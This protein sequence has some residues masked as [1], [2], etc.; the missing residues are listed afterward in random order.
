MN[1]LRFAFKALFPLLVLMLP[2]CQN[3]QN[4][5]SQS[6]I[7]KAYHDY[8]VPVHRP[9]NPENVRV[10]ISL[11]SQTAYVMEGE[12]ALLVMPVTVG[13]PGFSTPTGSFRIGEKSAK[14]RAVSHGFFRYGDQYVEGWTRDHGG[15]QMVGTPMP[16]WC[17]MAERPEIGMHTEW[18]YPEPH[19]HGCIR[20]HVNVAPRFFAIVHSGTPV[21]IARTQPYDKT[22]GASLKRPPSPA[23]LGEYSIQER[24]TDAF[25][26]RHKPVVFE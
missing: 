14:R 12:R 26:T 23:I 15:R 24:M 8:N 22:L 10:Y 13:R 20:M 25:F 6:A 2:A 1:P 18:V 11:E 21:N 19:S 4:G 9:N 16:Y 7:Y 17:G 3:L 5:R